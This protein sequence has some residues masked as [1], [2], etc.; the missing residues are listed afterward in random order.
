M[1]SPDI[2]RHYLSEAFHSLAQPITAVHCGLEIAI[3]KPRSIDEYRT[4]IEEAL[5]ITEGFRELTAALRELVE[6]EHLGTDVE[7]LDLPTFLVEVHETL[8]PIAHLLDA[9]LSF[10]SAAKVNV[11]ASRVKLLRVIV[12][13]SE[14]LLTQREQLTFETKRMQ[15][16]VELSITGGISE[17]EHAAT[18]WHESVRRI[19]TFAAENYLCTVGGKLVF[20]DRRCIL[21]IPTTAR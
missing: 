18:G 10:R 11:T 20:S 12:F 17:E 1:L 4:R 6:A 8:D 2:R 5:Q 21:Q 13:L 15:N 19:R 16:T 14:Q 3:A 9:S 7:V